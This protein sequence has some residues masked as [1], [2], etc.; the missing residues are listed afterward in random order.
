[1]AKAFKNQQDMLEA[2]RNGFDALPNG[3]LFSSSVWMAYE[4]GRAMMGAKL[5]RP[6][7]ARQ[8]RGYSVRLIEA[9]GTRWVV[10]FIGDAMRP[11]IHL[12]S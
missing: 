3:H 4:A 12:D 8:S 10:T 2:A 9:N 1:M 7:G 11:Q 6:I 5:G